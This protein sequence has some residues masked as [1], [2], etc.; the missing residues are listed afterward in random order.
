MKEGGND[1]SVTRTAAI[2]RLRGSVAKARRLDARR[3]DIGGQGR[4]VGQ[5][6]AFQQDTP[7]FWCPQMEA[8]KCALP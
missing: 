8:Q 4:L 6:P 3:G 7:P 2:T 1:M 5:S